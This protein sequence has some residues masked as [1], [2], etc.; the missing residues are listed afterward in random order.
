MNLNPGHL[1]TYKALFPALGTQ[2]S[3]VDTIG[4]SY[5]YMQVSNRTL[6]GSNI[7]KQCLIKY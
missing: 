7:N 2:A 3:A 1:S 4:D 5:L 6:L